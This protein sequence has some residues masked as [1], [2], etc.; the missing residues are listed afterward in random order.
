MSIPDQQSRF[1]DLLGA[2]LGL[3]AAIFLVSSPWQVDTSGPDPFY[4]GPLI[5]PLLVL[6]F[7]VISAIPSVVRLVKPKQG[8][9]WRLD[10][11]GA[12]GKTV[13]ILVFLLLFLPALFFFGLE[14][15]AWA[16]LF[17]SLYFLGYRGYGKLLFLPAI[18][19]G[20]TV[21]VF[22]HLL[23]VYFP[24]PILWELMGW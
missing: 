24:E 8:Q 5:Y 22:K 19:V 14:F 11:E 2:G 16:F 13:V 23:Q 6:I 15:S 17:A 10:G 9:S 7:M 18:A 1:H 3:L 4:K 20:L 21:L 12:P